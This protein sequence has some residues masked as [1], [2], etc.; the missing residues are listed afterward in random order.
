MDIFSKI[1]AG[2]YYDNW[3]REQRRADRDGW[4]AQANAKRAQ[5]KADA[6]EYVELSGHPKADAAF[7]LAS[8]ERDSYRETV[9]FL[10][11]LAQLL[12]D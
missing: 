3:T 8:Q 10:S 2:L 4:I 5:F 7:E 9:E 11:D 12:R 6:L 1:E